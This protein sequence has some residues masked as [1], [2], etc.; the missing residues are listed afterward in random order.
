MFTE[1]NLSGISVFSLSPPRKDFLLPYKEFAMY[2]SDIFQLDVGLR[3]Y[4][5]PSPLTKFPVGG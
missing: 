1:D 4:I 3:A 5:L 2:K